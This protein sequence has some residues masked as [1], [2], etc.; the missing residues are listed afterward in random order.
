M[1]AADVCHLQELTVLEWVEQG[2]MAKI[3]RN[4]LVFVETTDNAEMTLALFNFR[5]VQ[6]RFLLSLNNLIAAALSWITCR[7]VRMV[8]GRY[9]CR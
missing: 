5:R 9:C 1:I 2:V 8:V 7:H 4:K 6:S 3:Q